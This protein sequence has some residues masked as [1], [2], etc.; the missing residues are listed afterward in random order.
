MAN[1]SKV[2][3]PIVNVSAIAARTYTP[4]TDLPVGRYTFWVR[5][6][7]GLV[8]HG[9]WSVPFQFE[10]ATAPVLAGPPSPTLVTKPV[11]TWNNMAVPVGGKTAGADS[12]DF[13]LYKVDPVTFKYV[14][15]PLVTGLTSPTYTIPT[16][17]AF[18]QYRAV[19]RAFVKGR[20]TT[21]TLRGVN[22]TYTEFSN[23]INFTVGAGP[24]VNPIPNSNNRTPTITWQAMQGA[25]K[26][27]VYISN[28][29]STAAVV[30]QNGVTGTSWTVTPPLAPGAYRVWVRAVS[31]DGTKTSD[32]STPV[33]WTISSTTQPIDPLASASELIFAV[34]PQGIP[35]LSVTST[36]VSL[37]DFDDSDNPT[38]PVN[39]ADIVGDAPIVVPVPQS[40]ELL[41][42]TPPIAIE[43]NSAEHTDDVLAGW[44]KQL[45]WDRSAKDSETLPA[46]T[47]DSAAR[48][49]K[50]SASFG[51]LGAL[52]TL[53][54]KAIR[55]KRNE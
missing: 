32:W 42:M 47:I 38:A 41:P 51:I 39:S 28:G 37:A 55:R 31:T 12:Y 53:V 2:I 29:T 17:L 35:Q 45:W 22:P 27:D 26:Y 10:V 54:P 6:T 19:V 46:S 16:D 43:E 5:A 25:G 9:Y 24:I 44:D 36:T 18:G 48:T 7:N 15:L 49:P 50:S 4:S 3:S 20:V 33:Q 21:P 1:D 23:A 30:R 11:F 40:I 14:A 52:L 8:Q 34:V 13:L